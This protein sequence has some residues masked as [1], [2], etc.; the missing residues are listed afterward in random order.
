VGFTNWRIFGIL[1][2]NFCFDV[3]TSRKFRYMGKGGSLLHLI[4]PFRQFLSDCV[5]IGNVTSWKD[6]LQSSSG[7]IRWKNH[8]TM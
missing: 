8:V 4:V 3:M 7:K 6:P 2:E 1:A 5:H